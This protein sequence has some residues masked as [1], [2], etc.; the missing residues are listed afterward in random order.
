M[1]QLRAPK[2]AALF[3]STSVGPRLDFPDVP[4]PGEAAARLRGTARPVLAHPAAPSHA[5]PRSARAPGAARSPMHLAAATGPRRK[6]GGWDAGVSARRSSA[7]QPAAAAPPPPRKTPAPGEEPKRRLELPG[8]ELDLTGNNF[9]YEKELAK[10]EE[11]PRPQPANQKHREAVQRLYAEAVANRRKAMERLQ[12]APESFL[13]QQ[14]PSLLGRAAAVDVRP[15]DALF[16]I[17]LDDGSATPRRHRR[18]RRRA[19]AAA[20]PSQGL[21]A[22]DSGDDDAHRASVAAAGLRRG[23]AGRRLAGRSR[24]GRRRRRP[25]GGGGGGTL[26]VGC[27][28]RCPTS[29]G[30]TQRSSRRSSPTRVSL[31]PS[32]MTMTTTTR[33]SA[34]LATTNLP[35]RRLHAE[36]D[37]SRT[38]T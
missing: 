27:R 4:L 15:S 1:A 30:G 13:S 11:R 21:G 23:D 20:R 19:A 26:A 33:T 2:T 25:G 34:T 28:S 9:D 22:F 32:M 14:A 31:A 24:D 12:M 8:L 38:K 5:V 17:S 37:A 3:G 6:V 18:R 7:V 16:R 10:D 35:Y 36:G 29:R